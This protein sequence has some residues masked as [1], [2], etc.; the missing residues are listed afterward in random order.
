MPVFH[1][2]VHLLTLELKM[3]AAQSNNAPTIKASSSA[4]NGAADMTRRMVCGGLAGMIA[5]VNVLFVCVMH[6]QLKYSLY[7]I[8]N[9]YALHTSYTIRLLQIH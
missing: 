2:A 5:K 1:A 8:S 9:T 6:Q 3:A 7:F 4:T